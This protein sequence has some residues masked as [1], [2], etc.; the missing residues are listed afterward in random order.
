[1]I[2]ITNIL[3]TLLN[4]QSMQIACLHCILIDENA[5]TCAL[6]VSSWSL[7][8][9]NMCCYYKKN[10]FLFRAVQNY[11]DAFVCEW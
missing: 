8:Y 2:R 1:M 11:I 3:S 6:S 10:K 7:F 9:H 5:F 4:G